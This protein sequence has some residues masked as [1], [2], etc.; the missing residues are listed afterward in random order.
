MQKKK[1][2]PRPQVTIFSASLLRK[3]ITVKMTH[4]SIVDTD[5]TSNHL[6]H[7]DHITQMCFND[8]GFF[9][10]WGFLFG[11]AQLFNQTHGATLET[12]LKTSTST[13]VDKLL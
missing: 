3:P 8:S 5:N 13:G 11:L 4:L 7:D 9:I 12:T 10:G 2:I 1:S 6:R